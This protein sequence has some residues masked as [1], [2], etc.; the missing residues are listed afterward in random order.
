MHKGSLVFKLLMML[1]I[2]LAG[3]TPVRVERQSSD[4]EMDLSGQWNDIDA[5]IMVKSIGDQ[6]LNSDWVKQQT[7]EKQSIIFD[8]I[9]NKTMEHV[10]TD[11]ILKMLEQK[12]LESKKFI[13]LASGTSRLA[14]RQEKKDYEKNNEAPAGI[15]ITKEQ[16]AKYIIRGVLHSILDQ[17]KDDKTI[18]YQLTLNVV[19]INQNKLV[20]SG[21]K[22]IKKLIQK[23]SMAW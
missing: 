17:L 7:S 16:E 3:C 19:E 13:V 21:Q 9:E 18:Y 1:L 8:R 20:W 11:A 22:R 15:K 2:M 4:S 12:F 5:K 10:E 6:F 23:S 14:A